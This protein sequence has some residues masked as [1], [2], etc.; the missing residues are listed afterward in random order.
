MERLK[1]KL[2]A[3]EEDFASGRAALK[4]TYNETP[5][6]VISAP[7]RYL[8]KTPEGFS[9]NF[10]NSGK[11]GTPTI[12]GDNLY[13]Q[14]GLYSSNYYCINAINGKYNWGLRLG[15]TGISPAVYKNGVILINTL[16]FS[17]CN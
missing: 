15:E 13:V 10:G 6:K 17:L 3:A 12:V 11:A 7:E 9:I 16:L 1:A 14:E 2:K 4:V 5:V 8:M